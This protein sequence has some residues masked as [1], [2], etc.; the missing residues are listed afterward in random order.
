MVREARHSDLQRNIIDFCRLLRERDMLVTPSEVIDALRTADAVDLSDRQEFKMALRS[1]LTA[2]PEDIP[3]HD[4]TFDEFWRTRLPE[5]IE[6]RGEEGVASQD[7]EA[8]GQ[9]MAQPQ[10]AQGDEAKDDDEEGIDMPLY[11]PVEVLA[12]RDF[13]SF[14][15][16]EMSDIA[17]AILVVAKRLATRESRRY[18]S[19]QRGHAIDL[20]RTM[21]RN[22]KYGGT[23]VELARKKRKIRK[24]KIVLVCDVSRS[25]DTYSKFLLQF[26]YALQNTLGRVESFV[27]STRL[28]RVT[29][30][31]RTSDI[32][33]A[34]DRIT[35]EVPDWSGGT[36]IG[37]S[38]RTF[39]HEWAL[40][41]LNKHTIVLIMSDGLDTGDA[42]V[43]EHEMEQIQ[44]RAARVIWLNPLL[45]NEDYRPLARGMSAALPHVNL[46]ASAHNLASLQALGRHLAL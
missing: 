43:L 12:G 38:L 41:L 8:Q 44:R 5:R 21:R 45:G 30:Y 24:P 14:V 3:L 15:A 32:F 28:T 7:P 2:K 4:A 36:R 17:R 9:E 35:R 27:F 22:I 1:V 10:I 16:D 25:M 26:I 46:F 19:T 13:S 23:V 31:F 20:R 33:T 34:L 40:R 29:D 18:R 39:N 42:S 6:E 37:E 11:S